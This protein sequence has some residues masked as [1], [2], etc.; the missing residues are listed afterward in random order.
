[1]IR[2]I[3]VI[4]AGRMGGGIAKNLAR[5]D[6]FD[7]TVSDF[8]RQAVQACV[9]AG[10]ADGGS[11]TAAVADADL[12]ITSLPM[13]ETVTAVYRD[14]IGSSPAD[15][16]W[17]DVST[18]DP[19]TASALER[20]VE[21]S[22]RRFV[23]CP[24]G[25]GPAQAEAGTLPL[26]VGGKEEL[27]EPLEPVFACIG[28]GVHYMGSVEA[29]TSFKIVSNMIGM[30]NLAVMSEGYAL[31]KECGVTDE[32]FVDALRNT[33]AWSAQADL[34]LPWIMNG[35]FG[36]RFGV[37]LALKDVRLAVDIAARRGI[38][39]PV[40]ASGLSQLVAAHALGFGSEDADAVFKVV[41]PGSR[42]QDGE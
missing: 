34:R 30:T 9:D 39:A 41:V 22:G 6:A 15:T 3:T 20:T 23:A 26:F 12:V 32:A 42:T 33:G 38:P 14:A 2:R 35:D 4:G 1:M 7:V 13:P 24:L 21:S 25:K 28:E 10:A 16:L 27:L 5:D 37:D 19:A 11:A 31:C 18:I 17:M 29:S 40:G 36:N 8:S